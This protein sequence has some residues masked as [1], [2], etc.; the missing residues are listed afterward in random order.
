[1]AKSFVY[2]VCGMCTVR[3]PIKVHIQ[4]GQVSFIEGNPHVPAMKGLFVPGVQPESPW[5]KTMNDPRRP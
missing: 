1:M 2:S 5:S 4:N 3:C